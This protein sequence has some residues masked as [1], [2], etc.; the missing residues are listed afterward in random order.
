[1]EH[2]NCV[3]FCFCIL[4]LLLIDRMKTVVCNRIYIN[5]P[6]DEIEFPA[7]RKTTTDLTSPTSSQLA[8]MSP[9][10]TVTSCVNSI[11]SPEMIRPFLTA[12]PRKSS[13]R[14]RRKGRTLILTDTPVKA[15]LEAYQR[16][17]SSSKTKSSVTDKKRKSR[18]LCDLSNAVD[19]ETSEVIEKVSKI[20]QAHKK[21]VRQKAKKTAR[22]KGTVRSRRSRGQSI[23]DDDDT[24]CAMC[25]K[26]CNEPPLEDWKQCLY[27]KQWFHERCFPEDTDTCYRCLG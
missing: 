4:G 22:K 2:S 7:T 17:R 25:G 1:M 15:Q 27:C 16:E 8:D 12:R 11:I 3:I 18:E 23:T 5:V 14:A 6:V 24:P 21:I 13:H 20:S 26:R 10:A 19:S 9:A